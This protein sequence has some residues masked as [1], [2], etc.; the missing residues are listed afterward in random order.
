MKPANI[1]TD[2]SGQNIKIGDFGLARRFNVPFR[3]YSKEIVTLWYK[4]P[5]LL[6]G[7]KN[8]GIGVDIWS[9]GCIFIELY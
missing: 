4:A 7:E 3:L 8:Y 9:L 2:E 5:E 1:L 6:L